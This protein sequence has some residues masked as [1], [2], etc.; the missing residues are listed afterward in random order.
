MAALD[1]RVCAQAQPA[2]TISG[3]VVSD[4]G[5]P[6]AGASLFVRAINS[7]IAPRSTTTD[8]EGNFRLDGLDPALY[9]ITASAPAYAF[10]TT[11]T[12]T[13]YRIGDAVRLELVRGGVITGTVTNNAGEPV[14]GLRVRA[15]RIRDAAGQTTRTA[16][17]G[18]EQLTDDRGVYRIYGL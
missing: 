6:L 3:Q 4:S 18:T 15:V 13:Y 2:G 5:Q 12:A 1:I 7:P 14:I 16:S 8:A 9:S 17:T 10:D 11:A